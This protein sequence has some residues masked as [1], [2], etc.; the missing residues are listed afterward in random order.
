MECPKPFTIDPVHPRVCGEQ[1]HGIDN[2]NL[3]LG[4][5]PRVRGTALFHEFHQLYIRFIPACAGNSPTRRGNT[6]ARS[7]HPRVCGEQAEPDLHRSSRVGSSPRVRGTERGHMCRG[8]A[9]RF[10][11]ACAGNSRVCCSQLTLPPVHPRV[12][13]EQAGMNWRAFFNSG[14]SP[15]VRGTVCAWSALLRF[16]RFIPACAGNSRRIG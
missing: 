16:S 1:E 5:S 13:G 10:I 11:P 12:C 7:V 8:L 9:A 15:R 2:I 14:S 3:G 4:S 6:C